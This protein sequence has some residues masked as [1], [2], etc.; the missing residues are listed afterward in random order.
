M[1][2]R[3]AETHV[4]EKQ[5]PHKESNVEPGLWDHTLSQMLSHPGVPK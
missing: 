2:E 1:K 4:K 3:E 5:A